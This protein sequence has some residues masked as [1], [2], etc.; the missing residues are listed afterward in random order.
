MSLLLQ[1]VCR[2]TGGARVF[3]KNLPRLV[4]RKEQ[5]RNVWRDTRTKNKEQKREF[6]AG[7]RVS[8][9]FLRKRKTKNTFQK[10]EFAFVLSVDKEQSL[11]LHVLTEEVTE[12]RVGTSTSCGQGSQ[13]GE[14]HLE[15]E[16]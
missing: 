8:S 11:F 6:R 1:A 9:C 3:C 14:R 2:F 15:Y 5:N 10:F 12:G 16:G 4:F 7:G 13:T